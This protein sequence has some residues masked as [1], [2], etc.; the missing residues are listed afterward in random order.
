[1]N[2]LYNQYNQ[3]QNPYMQQILQQQM[4]Q[5]NVLPPQQILTASGDE[6]VRQ[7]K[8]SPN[9]SVLIAHETEPI[10]WRCVSDSIGNVT[11]QPFDVSPR[12]DRRQAETSRMEALI[13]EFNTGLKN[14][15]SVLS[16]IMSWRTCSIADEVK[17][18]EVKQYES[19]PRTKSGKN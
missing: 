17:G 5:Q 12:Q 10:V 1:M 9:S 13:E 3:M 4:A 14:M 6:S 15:N 8:M 16:E 11:V 18:Q 7:L 19:A 2:D